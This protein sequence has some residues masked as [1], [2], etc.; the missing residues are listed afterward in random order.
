MMR[1]FVQSSFD[2]Y[3]LVLHEHAGL[4][5]SIY[6]YTLVGSLSFLKVFFGIYTYS[7]IKVQN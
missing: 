3:R 6:S 5:Q 7:L 1:I 4:D 2:Y